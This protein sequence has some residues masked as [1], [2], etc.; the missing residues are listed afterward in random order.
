MPT[1]VEIVFFSFVKVVFFRVEE[2]NFWS[3]CDRD[4]DDDICIWRSLLVAL[5]LLQQ[6][7]W[8]CWESHEIL[9]VLKAPCRLCTVFN[10][11]KI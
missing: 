6:L 8:H 2:Y 10:K 1:L 3:V 9:F 7:P 5:L 4:D 11:V